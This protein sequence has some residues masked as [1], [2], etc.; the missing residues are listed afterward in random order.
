MDGNRWN[1]KHVIDTKSEKRGA[2]HVSEKVQK[3][4]NSPSNNGNGEGL[5]EHVDR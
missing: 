2:I 1:K 5:S 4:T 3:L